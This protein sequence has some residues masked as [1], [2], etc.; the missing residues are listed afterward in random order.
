MKEIK[1]TKDA[2]VSIN[3]QPCQMLKD[4]TY[5]Y[6]YIVKNKEVNVKQLLKDSN[7]TRSC[8]VFD[9]NSI[10]LIMFQWDNPIEIDIEYGTRKSSCRNCFKNLRE[11]CVINY[12]ITT[13]ALICQG[14]IPP[15]KRNNIVYI[16]NFIFDNSL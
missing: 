7:I 9:S 15:W 13:G 11:D 12:S 1:I 16:V 2:K 5:S 10:I 4:S 6:A 8:L 14:F 3:G